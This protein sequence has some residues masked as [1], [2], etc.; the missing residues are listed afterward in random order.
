[1]IVLPLLLSAAVGG[2]TC[3]A[4]MTRRER[5]FRPLRAEMRALRAANPN[6]DPESYPPLR[7][8]QRYRN[9]QS[10]LKAFQ[11][12]YPGRDCRAEAKHAHHR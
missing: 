3:E 5:A 7:L 8:A 1:M 2:M 9:F 4:A 11:R 12:R 6:H 10:N